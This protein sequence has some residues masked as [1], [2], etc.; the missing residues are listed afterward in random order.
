[1][2]RYIPEQYSDA[3]FIVQTSTSDVT[4]RF[5]TG[6]YLSETKSGNIIEVSSYGGTS[7]KALYEF[8]DVQVDNLLD[9]TDP[10]T[11]EKLGISFEQMKLT[12]VQNSYDYRFDSSTF[13]FL[14]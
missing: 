6:L 13:Y 8:M 2:Y 5:R 4:N 14:K 12:S 3:K 10:N 11:I 7:G 1:M 9:L